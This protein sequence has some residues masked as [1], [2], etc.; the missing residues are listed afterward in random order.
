M[1]SRADRDD[2][3][4]TLDNQASERLHLTGAALTRRTGLLLS[5]DCTFARWRSFGRQL[6][7]ISDSSTWWLGD[8]LVFG[9]KKF[10]D[11]YKK[12]VAE[13]GLDYK[14]LRNYAWVAGKVPIARRRAS[15]SFQHHAE[16]APLSPEEQDKWLSAAEESRWTRCMLRKAIKQGVA[17]PG[18]AE[19][20][21]VHV[22]LSTTAEYE[23]AWTQAAS[24]VGKTLSE[25]ILA[26][27]NEAA[28]RSL[29][30]EA[31]QELD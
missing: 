16:V 18:S 30:Q 11:R 13:T 19:R 25:W 3:F 7:L 5:D 4:K 21:E 27:L 17:E 31:I 9:R 26:S 1:R 8:W 12:A 29:M 20:N 15:L 14:T 23:E 22:R 28:S 24:M 6:F 10:P 2:E